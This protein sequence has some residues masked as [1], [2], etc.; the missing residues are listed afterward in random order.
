MTYGNSTTQ[1][2]RETRNTEFTKMPYFW[3]GNLASKKKRYKLW[4]PKIHITA[5]HKNLQKI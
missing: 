4:M 3:R 5:Q 1:I 2:D